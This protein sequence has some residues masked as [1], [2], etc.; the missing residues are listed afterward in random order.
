MIRYDLEVFKKNIMKKNSI[1]IF[2]L[3]IQVL[4][5]VYANTYKIKKGVSL[6]F[7]PRKKNNYKD[8]N[9]LEI[10][11]SIS[12]PI[13]PNNNWEASR[14]EGIW[15]YIDDFLIKVHPNH[16]VSERSPIINNKIKIHL[17]KKKSR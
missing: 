7:F 9:L 1:Y 10:K 16:S 5:C 8:K 17:G 12:P 4:N 13:H 15:V 3:M 6:E 2:I 14:G 11:T